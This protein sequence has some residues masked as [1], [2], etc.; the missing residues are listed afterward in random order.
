MLNNT[1]EVKK[2]AVLRSNSH[3]GL[4]QPEG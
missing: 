2:T 4:G 1:V 3:Y